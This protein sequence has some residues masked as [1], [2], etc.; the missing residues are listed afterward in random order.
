MWRPQGCQTG[1]GNCSMWSSVRSRCT[2]IH[3]YWATQKCTQKCTE[4]N[5]ED[6]GHNT[7]KSDSEYLPWFIYCQNSYMSI[8]LYLTSYGLKVQITKGDWYV[9]PEKTLYRPNISNQSHG[10]SPIIFPEK[11]IFFSFL[12]SVSRLLSNLQKKS[13]LTHTFLCC[14][15]KYK[16]LHSSSANVK[17]C[18]LA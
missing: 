14:M 2:E 12:L 1:G 13:Q 8:R 16:M 4:R 9:G 5:S 3:M 11:K 15:V 18:Q 7:R 6:R 10:V 17:Y